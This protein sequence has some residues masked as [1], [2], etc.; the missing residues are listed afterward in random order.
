M[1]GGEDKEVE[2]LW[3]FESNISADTYHSFPGFRSLRG[4]DYTVEWRIMRLKRV[5]NC[6]PTVLKSLKQ[7]KKRDGQRGKVHA[8]TFKNHVSDVVNQI[9]G[10]V[11]RF[12]Q[13][14][15]LEDPKLPSEIPE[16][17]SNKNGKQNILRFPEEAM[18]IIQDPSLNRL[19]VA[20]E[21]VSLTKY[22]AEELVVRRRLGGNLLSLI[23]SSA[24][25][26]AL[27]WPR[28]Q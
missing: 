3:L 20:V 1:D 7:K 25:S 8:N 11:C 28:S 5:A 23:R 24:R 9:I 22:V 12:E 17:N 10:Q 27:R 2:R 13:I 26:P 19:F 18:R 14:W 6:R 4:T 16:C 21:S 15:N